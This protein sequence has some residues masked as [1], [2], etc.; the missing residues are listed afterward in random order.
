[1]KKVAEIRHI[2]VMRPA[3]ADIMYNV[4]NVLTVK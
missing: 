3:K 4:F 1:M 2:K